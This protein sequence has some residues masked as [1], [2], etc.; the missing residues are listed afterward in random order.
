LSISKVAYCG[1]SSAVEAGLVEKERM[2]FSQHPDQMYDFVQERLAAARENQ[3]PSAPA[4]SKEEAMVSRMLYRSG[5]W[6]I[7]VGRRLQ[8]TARPEPCSPRMV[9]E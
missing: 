7:Q 1:V 2:M 3:V 4:A 9:V 8:T 6:L 5:A